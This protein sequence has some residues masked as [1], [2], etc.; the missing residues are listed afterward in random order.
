MCYLVVN[1]LLYLR[2]VCPS[3]K[4]SPPKKRPK[5]D[6]LASDCQLVR[7]ERAIRP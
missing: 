1:V 3:G 7:T 5:F 6:G 4:K 2:Y